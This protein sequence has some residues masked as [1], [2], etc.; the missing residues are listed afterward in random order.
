MY[1]GE[2]RH[3]VMVA[4]AET[5]GRYGIPDRPVR[6]ADL[7]LRARPDR[8]R[9]PHLRSSCS[10]TAR[11]RPTRSATWSCMSP[12][13]FTPENAR[14]ADLTC[15][16]LQL[17]NFW[18]DVARD[19]AIGRIYLPRED[20]ARFGYSRVG[21]ACLALHAG[22]CGVDAIRGRA[23]PC[24]V[25]G[26][27]ALVPRMTGALAVDIDL[28]SRGGLAILD[29]IE[30]QRFDVLGA[31]PALSRWTKLGLLARHR[32]HGHGSTAR[33]AAHDDRERSSARSADGSGGRVVAQ[34]GL[35][36][37][38]DRALQASYRFCGAL[39]RREA[40][41]FYYAFLLLPAAGRR[42]MCALYAFLRHTDDLADE[43]GSAA[44]KAR[45]LDAWRLDLASALAGTGTAWPGL[46]ALADTV[47]RHSIPA[48]LLQE[49]IDG[50]SMDVEPRRFATFDEL[51]DYCYHVASVVGLAAFISGAI[52]P[53][54]ERPSDWPSRAGSR[55]N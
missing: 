15:T 13:R 27:S 28:F 23:S 9:I 51:T 43:P 12:V 29:Q 3:P 26:R 35:P 21:S 47:A 48:D 1:Q 4:L 54:G 20:R 6:G 41:N 49:V 46:A 44:A 14:L 30:A 40:R 5:V 37:K 2:A 52:G 11:G 36:M 22:V 50:V 10:T 17:A 39:A 38:T 25:R 19:L 55:C 32:G 33:R 8:H 42:S 18:Q 24:P 53:M 31:R 16:A 7:G 45:A 34:G